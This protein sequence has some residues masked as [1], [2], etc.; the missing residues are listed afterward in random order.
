MKNQ[1]VSA[2][3]AATKFTSRN[4]GTILTVVSI[5]G[6]CTTAWKTGEASVKAARVIEEMNYTSEE[7][8]TKKEIVKAVAPFYIEP[9]I[10][11]GVTITSIIFTRKIYLRR[12]AALAAAYSIADARYKEYR[13]KVTESL[14]EKKEKKLREEIA[15][16][17][18]SESPPDTSGLN[19][20][21]TGEGDVLFCDS[22]TMRYFYSSYEAVE[23]ARLELSAMVQDDNYASLNELY[24]ALKIPQTT[25]GDLLGWNIWMLGA[26][27][28]KKTLPLYTGNTIQTPTP[29]QLPCTV[30]DYE[31][32][33][34]FFYDDY[35]EGRR[36]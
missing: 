14:G 26:N 30:I 28:D 13:E 24:S 9:A 11:A 22:Y 17:K 33:P 8:P 29:E 16:K 23:R 31:L 20:I 25:L 3:N 6:V 21:H 4:A 7:P 34:V 32:E 1:I 27:G 36:K 12:Q 18:V 19:I 2:A 35:S 10:A 15:E 5:V